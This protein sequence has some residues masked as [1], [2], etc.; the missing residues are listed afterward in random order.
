MPLSSQA[1]LDLAVILY[2]TDAGFR[3]CVHQV[4]KSL[5]PA[6]DTDPETAGARALLSAPLHQATDM[7]VADMALR[8]HE[9]RT[10]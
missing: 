6:D 9:R 8:L 5:R 3:A 1:R 2:E 7:T 10:G 4:I